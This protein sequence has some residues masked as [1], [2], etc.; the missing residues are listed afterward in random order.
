MNQ[1]QVHNSLVGFID[2]LGFSERVLAAASHDDPTHRELEQIEKEIQNLHEHFEHVPSNRPRPSHHQAMEKKVY[3]VSDCLLLSMSLDSGGASDI[4]FVDSIMYEIQNI[5][6]SQAKSVIEDGIFIRGGI[7]QGLWYFDND[8]L[9]SPAQVAAYKVEQSV[10]YPVIGIENSLYESLVNHHDLQN[11]ADPGEP[12]T[13]LRPLNFLPVTHKDGFH[14]IDYLNLFVQLS[15]NVSDKEDTLKKHRRQVLDA[16]KRAPN[17]RIA[18][19]YEWLAQYHDVVCE[20]NR[21]DV[22][23]GLQ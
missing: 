6:I 16:Q 9:I 1:E 15:N 21:L 11:Y 22:K 23:C 7:A 3:A 10:S 4:G 17:S 2:L 14:F 18:A 8:I 12:L 20:S 13:N 19:K 5:G